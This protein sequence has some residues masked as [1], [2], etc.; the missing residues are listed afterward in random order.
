MEKSHERTLAELR[1]THRQ[2][3]DALQ[4]EKDELLQSEAHDT[5]AGLYPVIFLT[6]TQGLE[7]AGHVA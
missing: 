6:F 4:Q 2:E 3:I 5:Q 1:A 7:H